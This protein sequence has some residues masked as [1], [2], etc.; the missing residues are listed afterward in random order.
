WAM[1]AAA[2]ATRNDL[3]ARDDALQRV[4]TAATYNM[5]FPSLAPIFEAVSV[6]AQPPMVWTMA[7]ATLIGWSSMAAITQST[8]LTVLCLGRSPMDA[9]RR[10]ACDRLANH[11]LE[12]DQTVVAFN[13]ATA[14][15]KKLAWDPARLKTL[16]D[17]K[18]VTLGLGRE[19]NDEKTMFSCSGI[20]R[21]KQMMQKTLSKG[22]RAIVRD[23]IAASG[24]TLAE[25]ADQYRKKYPGMTN[26]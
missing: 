8:P 11:V 4:M 6:N 24:M 13:M 15:G 25:L 16:A 22:E 23:Y 2:A 26:D 17:E 10:A 20:L 14:T 5:R 18:W 19:W 9:T 3:R 21:T 1:I 12:N 7:G